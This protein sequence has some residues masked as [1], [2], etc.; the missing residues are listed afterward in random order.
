M[1]HLPP[2]RCYALGST[3]DDRMWSPGVQPQMKVR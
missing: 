2:V 1:K 3:P